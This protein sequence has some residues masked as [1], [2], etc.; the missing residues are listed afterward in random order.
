MAQNEE[1]SS[2][3]KDMLKDIMGQF[4]QF[5]TE[6]KIGTRQRR[7]E[8]ENRIALAQK[9]MADLEQ[10]LKSETK[11]RQ[12][13]NKSIQSWMDDEVGTMKCDFA[14]WQE[15][16]K[17][18]VEERVA[19]AKGRL[20]E[21]EEGFDQMQIDI[22]ALIKKNTDEINQEFWKFQ[23]DFEDEKIRRMKVE[24]EILNRLANH[25]HSVSSKFESM[26]DIRQNKF[27]LLQSE[28]DKFQ[29]LKMK[30]EEHFKKFFD[31]EVAD[32]KNAILLESQVRE[33]EDDEMVEAMNRY[34]SQLQKSLMVINDRD[35]GTYASTK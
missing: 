18:H 30:A 27:L 9:K 33:R 10:T 1:N 31:E 26:R 23:K 11:R 5:D 13:M 22:P 12:E 6:M 25:E 32:I 35:I 14:D 34:A 29:K 8:D 4:A 28:F 16:S 17:V 3:T 21:L 7:E 2:A 24:G 19:K 15:S 20:D